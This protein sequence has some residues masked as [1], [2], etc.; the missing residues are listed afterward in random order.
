MNWGRSMAGR[1]RTGMMSASL[2]AV[3]AAPAGA[4]ENEAKNHVSL[5]RF[6][7]EGE[8]FVVNID[9]S[10]PWAHWTLANPARIIVDLGD[11]MSELPNAPGLYETP[12]PAHEQKALPA[13]ESM[14]TPTAH[15]VRFTF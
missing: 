8:W 15:P 13:S 10:A 9:T 11:A 2:L 12:M 7:S 4:V 1:F 3:L 5:A 6:S 14:H